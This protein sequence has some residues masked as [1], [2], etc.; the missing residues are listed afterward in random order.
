MKML[1]HFVWVGILSVFLFSCTKTETLVVDNNTP[2]PDQTP[3]SFNREAY[4][5]RVFIS[6]IGRKPTNTEEAS[7]FALIPDAAP[8]Q[9]Q[10]EALLET[11][12]L[13][14]GYLARS[15]DNARIDLLNN[16]DTAEISN[17]LATFDQIINSTT[18]PILIDQINREKI[19]LQEMLTIP[20]D[21]SN[22]TLD[23]RGLHKRCIHN[24]FYDQINMGTANFVISS[25]QN[26][27]FRPP[28]TSEQAQGISMV[29][30]FSG[31]LFL[32]AGNSK[33]DYLTIFFNSQHYAEG[34]VKDAF[35]RYLF[36]EPTANEL[37]SYTVELF[38]D[39][40]YNRLVKKL[41]SSTE[42]AYQ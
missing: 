17:M 37:S 5:N 12:F 23:R 7:A 35:R 28:T 15:Y 39:W 14:P 16:L 21:L 26:F 18:D 27:L 6:L 8:T 13:N 42:Y 29:D 20:A 10:L 24:W 22:G 9:A 31:T 30:G 25:F 3:K 33:T 4:L 11:V 19:R 41:L 38:S 2:P 32:S 34:Q 36:R 1:Q 40:N